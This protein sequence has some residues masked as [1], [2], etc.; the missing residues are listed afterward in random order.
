[1]VGFIVD[2]GY[3]RLSSTLSP[4]SVYAIS[5]MALLFAKI[6]LKI[7]FSSQLRTSILKMFFRAQPWWAI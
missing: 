2:S 1:M 7:A 5:K 3:E 4:N 6:K